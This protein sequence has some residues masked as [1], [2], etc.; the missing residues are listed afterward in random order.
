M[1]NNTFLDVTLR[2]LKENWEF[3]QEI[4]VDLFANYYSSVNV[5]RSFLYFLPYKVHEV[6]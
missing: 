3:L 5:D 4:G 1:N 2:I 6:F